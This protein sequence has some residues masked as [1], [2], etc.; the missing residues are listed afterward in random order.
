MKFTAFRQQKVTNAKEKI[1]INLVGV[2]IL[3][4]F[5]VDIHWKY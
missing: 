4:L 5:I 3:L 1:Y 2:A